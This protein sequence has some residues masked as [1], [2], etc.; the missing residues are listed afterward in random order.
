MR[1]CFKSFSTS[2]VTCRTII[3]SVRPHSVAYLSTRTSKTVT[4]ASDASP[5][6]R[7]TG[8]RLSAWIRHWNSGTLRKS[9][10]ISTKNCS[11][12]Y[13][14]PITGKATPT[15]SS[16]HALSAA[17]IQLAL[18]CAFI[19]LSNPATPLVSFV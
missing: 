17:K 19:S 15:T 7:E 10:D 16:A 14:H 11:L 13:Q 18:I 9:I 3:S 2:T 4:D 12:W 6:L 5:D 1:C 8:S